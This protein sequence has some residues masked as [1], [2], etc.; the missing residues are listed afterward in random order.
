[1]F[2]SFSDDPAG[3]AVALT[4][5]LAP[6]GPGIVVSE[7]ATVQDPTRLKRME[8]AHFVNACDALRTNPAMSA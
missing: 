4:E 2:Q 8:W 3:H 1:V 6:V 7:N 5:L